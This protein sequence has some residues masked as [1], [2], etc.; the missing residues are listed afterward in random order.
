MLL[1]VPDMS[2]HMKISCALHFSNLP[3]DSPPTHTTLMQTNPF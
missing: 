3:S 2:R 1:T